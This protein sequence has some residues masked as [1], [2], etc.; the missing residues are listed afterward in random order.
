[1]HL[2]LKFGETHKEEQ[3]TVII[4][5]LKLDNGLNNAMVHFPRGQVSAFTTC[6]QLV[7][8]HKSTCVFCLIIGRYKF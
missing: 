5:G 2:N 1:M 4:D 3:I 6:K 7:I 8:C